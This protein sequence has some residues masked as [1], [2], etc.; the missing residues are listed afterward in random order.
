MICFGRCE[1]APSVALWLCALMMNPVAQGAQITDED[2][3]RQATDQ[4]LASLHVDARQY[5]KLRRR[6][7][8]EDLYLASHGGITET[9]FFFEASNTGDEVKGT[10]VIHHLPTDAFLDFI[11][12]VSATSGE[13]FRIG[14]FEDSLAEF[15]RL[16]LRN[17]VRV[18]RASQAEAI[19]NFYIAVSREKLTLTV[20]KSPMEYKQ[21]LERQCHERGGN[22]AFL[23]KEF[24]HWWTSKGSA[25]VNLEFKYLVAPSFEGFK[26]SF[27]IASSPINSGRCGIVPV[28]ATIE[29]LS[30]A[31]VSPITFGRA[32]NP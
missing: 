9:V 4:I 14:G 27:V 29:V 16:N 31:V 22:F 6:E 1:A 28:I 26:V 8:I 19:V 24:G 13:V 32:R 10:T 7:D 12:G 18:T 17:P 23:Q 5:L 21:A 15:N 25:Y 3:R 30:S 20:L 11:V 2:A